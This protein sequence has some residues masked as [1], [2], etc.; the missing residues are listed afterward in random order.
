MMITIFGLT[1]FS[2]YSSQLSNDWIERLLL[3]EFLDTGLG[4]INTIQCLFHNGCEELVWWLGLYLEMWCNYSLN[5]VLF[6]QS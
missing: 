5:T 1:T 4:Y 3:W 6:D 2:K